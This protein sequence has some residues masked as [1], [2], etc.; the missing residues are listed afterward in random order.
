MRGI[1]A[2]PAHAIFG[3]VMGYYLGMARFATSGAGIYLAKSLLVPIMLHGLY[4]YFLLSGIPWLAF[5]LIP[6]LLYLYV[7]GY[8]RMKALN[9][10]KNEH[11]DANLDPYKK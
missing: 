9:L 4:D 7:T 2:V 8:R 1:T 5:L 10:M 3:I 11:Y 6:Y